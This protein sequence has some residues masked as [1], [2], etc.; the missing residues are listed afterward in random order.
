MKAEIPS[1][2]FNKSQDYSRAKLRFG[3]ISDIYDL[4]Q[5]LTIIHFDILPLIWTFSGSLMQKF[6]SFLPSFMSGVVTKSIIFFFVFQIMS[7]ILS[8]PISYYSTFHLEEKYG[9]NKLD[10]K[11]WATD[12][13]KSIALMFVLGG[14]IIA[15][16]LKIIDYYGEKFVAYVMIFL[17]AVQLVMMTLA[18]SLILPL[19]NKFTPL[20][21]GELKT[22][23][24]DLALKNGFP[25]TKLYV[26]DGSKRSSHSNAYF[27]GLPWSKQIVLY[28][29]LI[30]HN[31]V[32]ETVAVLAHE[33]GHWKLSHIIRL[34]GLSQVQM[35]LTFLTFSAF[36][37]NKSL[38]A[39][40]G[41]VSEQPA[42]I[43]MTLFNFIFGPVESILQFALNLQSRKYEYQADAYAKESGYIDNLSSALIKLCRENLSSINAD[44]LYSA[45]HH[46]HPILAERLKALGYV[47]K[48]K[49]SSKDD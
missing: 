39:A 49:V 13:L 1:D 30:N 28:D 29:T 18:P 26:V 8:L 33:I 35:F 3:T 16:L 38:Y 27:I 9:F 14:P 44:G 2:T 43:G 20:E 40:F 46:S 25:L 23:I 34:V 36:M 42:L 21:D 45:Y 37:Y 7:T 17:L 41:F 11:L 5:T 19:F 15:T 47:S 12:M 6:A 48:T 32:D 4:I 31:S 10:V 22:A 24:E